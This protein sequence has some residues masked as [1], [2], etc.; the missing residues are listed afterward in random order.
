MNSHVSVILPAKNAEHTISE[1]IE[2]VL[3]QSFNDLELIIAVDL[4]SD[5]TFD[6]AD[7]YRCT[8]N[9]VT[10]IKLD[11]NC[12]GAA[13]ARNAALSIAKSDYVAFLDSD[14]LWYSEKLEKQIAHLQATK[15]CVSYAGYRVFRTTVDGERKYIKTIEPPATL[16]YS[17]LLNGNQIGC[18][19]VVLRRDSLHKGGFPFCRLREDYALWLSLAR[20][21]E[22]FSG[23]REVLADYRLSDNSVSS[24]KI[25]VALSQWDVYR[26]YLNFRLGP[27]IYHFLRYAV[28]GT[29]KHYF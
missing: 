17:S 19:T 25:K 5:R 3:N 7:E 18:S 11:K 1:S 9:R 20:N 22:K 4:S 2:S 21:G 13:G 29:L 15:A 14:D 16:D 24:N 10:I 12:H 28:N 26:T 23:L 27:S 6:I 8:D